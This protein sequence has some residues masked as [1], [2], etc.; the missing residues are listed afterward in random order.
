MTWFVEIGGSR[1]FRPFNQQGMLMLKKTCWTGFVINWDFSSEVFLVVI[2][3]SKNTKR[4]FS[5]KSSNFLVKYEATYYFLKRLIA[6]FFISGTLCVIMLFCVTSFPLCFCMKQKICVVCLFV[7]CCFYFRL[8]Y[9]S[10]IPKP[11]I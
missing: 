7:Y 4:K 2:T 1:N 11:S 9:R 8:Y 6:L 5:F 10:E 3:L